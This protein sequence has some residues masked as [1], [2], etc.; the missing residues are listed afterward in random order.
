MLQF[1]GSKGW[2]SAPAQHLISIPG[3]S[4]ILM[5]G[6]LEVLAQFLGEEEVVQFPICPLPH[7]FLGSNTDVA[8]L[9]GEGNATLDSSWPFVP[10]PLASGGAQNI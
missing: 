7:W 8:T 3:K 2:L 1:V 10:H 9:D 4:K 6:G 5:T